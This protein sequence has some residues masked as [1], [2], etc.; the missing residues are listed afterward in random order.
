MLKIDDVIVELPE[1]EEKD[2]SI[3][4]QR[5][6][7]QLPRLSEKVDEELYEESGSIVGERRSSMRRS[8]ARR[9]INNSSRSLVLEQPL[10]GSMIDEN[11]ERDDDP[12]VL[13]VEMKRWLR[14]K[15][16]IKV[17]NGVKILL[18]DLI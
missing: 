10:D 9:K 2:D 17:L 5:P 12:E 4:K 3:Y 18:E 7:K 16:K 6:R 14:K 13:K 15:Y 11:P 8:S 1:E